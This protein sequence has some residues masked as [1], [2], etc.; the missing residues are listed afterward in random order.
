MSKR[1]PTPPVESPLWRTTSERDDHEAVERAVAAEFPAG[2]G[3]LDGSS[4]REFMQLIGGSLALA[5]VAGTMAGCKDPPEKVLPYNLKPE[6]VTPGKPL[7]YA[8][9]LTHA[10]Y[11]TGV[12]VTAW[13]G[14]PTKVEGNPEHPFSRGTT[15]THDQAEIMSL[16][17]TNRSRAL[18]QS[19]AGATWIGFCRTVEQHLKTPNLDGGAKLAFLVEPNGSPLLGS[20]Q[21]KIAAALPKARW[22]GH[23]ALTMNEAYEGARIAFGKPLETQLD[24]SKTRTVVSLDA[25]FLGAWPWYIQQ[26]RQWADSRKPGGNMSR[27]YVAEAALSCTGVMADHRLRSRSS[28]IAVVARALHLAVTGGSADAGNAKATA[29]VKTAAKDL[30]D[31]GNDAVVVVGP[32]Q[33][34][35][36]HAL[37][38]AINGALKS[39]AVRYSAPVLPIYE[40]LAALAQAAKAG[41]VDTLVISA[42][43]P[44]YTAPADIDFATTLKQIQNTIYLAPYDDE[45]AQRVG[46]VIPRA[47]E[48][49][50]WGDARA[51]DGTV[52]IQQP[53]MQPL[54]DGKSVAELWSAFLGKG[55]D[56]SYRLLRDSYASDELSFQRQLQKG[57][58][59]STPVA[60]N[61]ALDGNAVIAAAGKIAA[62]A[63]GIELNLVLDYKVFDGRY[64]NNVWMQEL[65]DPVTKLTWD[66]ALLISPAMVKKLGLELNAFVDVKLG[67]KTITLNVLPAVGHA[68]DSATVALGYGRGDVSEEHARSVGADAYQ[69][70]Q[71][72]SWFA[73]GVTLSDSGHKAPH[74]LALTQ[75]HWNQEGR[76]IALEVTNRAFVSKKLPIVEEQNAAVESMYEP[77]KYDGFKWAMAIDLNKCTGCSACVVACQAENNIPVVGREQVAKSR[78]MHWIR[79]DLY[80]SGDENDPTS[81]QPQPML[82]VHCEKAPCEYVCPVNATVH[83]DEGLNEMVYNRCIGTRYCSNNC[84]Y[85]VRRFNFLDY[86]P[87]VQPVARM[88]MNPDVTIRSRGVMEKCTYCVQRIERVRIEARVAGRPIADGD[89]VTACQQVCPSQ[90]ITF[91]SLHDKEAAVSKLHEDPRSY[92]VLHDLGTRPRTAHMARVKN[93]NPELTNG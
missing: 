41:N 39:T 30:L 58:V 91:G 55:G 17:D 73:T 47:H 13:E 88:A 82:C 86:H 81:V 5:G 56:G 4:R 43:N 74:K 79:L 25:D 19:G 28:D 9:A 24:L 22:F 44:V 29:W 31:G 49:E 76:P 12:L 71:G 83:S 16:Y 80:F 67:G 7:H 66:N 77:H 54:Y 61:N 68:D 51:V 45:T 93:Q 10:G 92:N 6:D 15:S 14:R 8:T 75:E 35:V 3:E 27:L 34:A 1:V 11:A 36:V 72:T 2:A 26:Q 69:L 46:W 21:K 38:H 33:P 59:D 89:V 52:T 90:A 37:A 70:R 53:L 40:P 78:E 62:A 50:T 57:V 63:G 42:W 60:E 20:L 85:K 18:T 64:G 87:D 65:P 48:L 32:R 23:A 84:P